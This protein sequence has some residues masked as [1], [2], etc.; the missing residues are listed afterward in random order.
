M[1]NKKASSPYRPVGGLHTLKP[2]LAKGLEAGAIIPAVKVVHDKSAGS[3]GEKY[4]YR[5]RI[6]LESRRISSLYSQ[7][8][9]KA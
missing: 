1:P 9:R 8:N 2:A 3:K 7:N 5:Y 6:I 4:L